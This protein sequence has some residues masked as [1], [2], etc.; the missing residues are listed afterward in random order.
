M[1]CLDCRRQLLVDPQRLSPE[2]QAHVTACVACQQYV[3]RAQEQDRQLLDAL[4]VPVPERLA[5]RILLRQRLQ[6]RR[7]WQWPAIAAVVMLSAG[8][9]TW[10]LPNSSPV[11]SHN[12]A[13]LAAQHV[14]AEPAALH[15][16]DV[17]A[18][19]TLSTAL[20]DWNTKLAGSLGILRYVDRCNMTTGK[21]LHVVFDGP[22]GRATLIVPP[23][24]TP[25]GERQFIGADVA[26]EVIMIG[27]QPVSIVAS[28]AEQL[29]MLRRAVS[30]A[31]AAL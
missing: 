28:N 25:V 13:E 11:S 15:K 16:E 24:D 17:V 5:D 1:N 2:V 22:A 8:V 3:L 27:S 21:G 4:S 29:P 31:L 14:L 9:L 6:Q 10:Q 19:D 26:A 30:T 23:R 18:A 12:L 7:H 20:A